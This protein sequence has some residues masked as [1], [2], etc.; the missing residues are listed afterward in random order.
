M[1][2]VL[3]SRSPQRR[4]LL[5]A[6]G[7]AH[8]VV[9][10]RYGEEDVPGVGPAQLAAI[11]ASE[12]ARDV[13]GRVGFARDSA[14]LGADTLVVVDDRA[15]GK[16][17]DRAEARTMLEALRG[18]SHVVASAV[19]LITPDGEHAFVDE[20]EV[21]FREFSPD[22][23]D[24]YLDQGEWQGR[25]GAYAIQGSGA[26]LV[27]RVNGDFTT[28]VGLPVGRLVALLESVGLAPWAAS[29]VT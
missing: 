23:I 14:V 27:A 19:C 11:H 12:K 7:I 13:A 10:S 16:P 15:L 9:T 29:P 25:A 26:S 28:V 4:A 1:T 6:A 2:L 5:R 21:V 20:A 3:A 8:R 24:W 17:A 18:R 22:Q